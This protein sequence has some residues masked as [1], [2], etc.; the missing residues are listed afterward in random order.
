[1]GVRL[2]NRS[3]WFKGNGQNKLI[4]EENSTTMNEVI[5][6]I[7]NVENQ[8]PDGMELREPETPEYIV[9]KGRLRC[10][11]ACGNDTLITDEV[12]QEGLNWNMIVGAEHYLQLHCEECGSDLK[13]YIEE[14]FEQDELPK[15]G[16]KE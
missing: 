5:D 11:C 2:I 15:E 8:Y 3:V 10:K 14:I 7:T 6:P 4:M 1:M 12:I 16:N 13:M 9:R